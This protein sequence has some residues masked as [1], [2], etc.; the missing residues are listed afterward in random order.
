MQKG[1]NVYYEI[2]N[3]LEGITFFADQQRLNS[4]FVNLLN[5]A[6]KFTMEGFIKIVVTTAVE[7][8]EKIAWNEE[9]SVH[10]D[11]MQKSDKR[12]DELKVMKLNFRVEDSGI[13]IKDEDQGKLF[14]FFGKVGENN[15]EINPTGIGLGLM[16]CN[17]ILNELGSNITVTS[18]YGVGTCFQFDLP[19]HVSNEQDALNKSRQSYSLFEM[20]TKNLAMNM[21][22]KDILPSVPIFPVNIK[23]YSLI[24]F[25]M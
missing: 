9:D 8:P 1:I 6:L 24:I 14:K 12:F 3:A 22:S 23:Y 10:L 15:S 17:K 7:V 11:L 19:L 21:N 25:I 16:I 13:G 20:E 18:K 4:V 2:E 5:N